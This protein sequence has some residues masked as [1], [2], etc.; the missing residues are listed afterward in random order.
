MLF[1]CTMLSTNDHTEVV[2]HHGGYVLQRHNGTSAIFPI[3]P[4]R[5]ISPIIIRNTIFDGGR[6][7]Y[8]A[9]EL[10]VGIGLDVL[11]T[12]TPLVATLEE[13]AKG[14]ATKIIIPSDLQGIAGLTTTIKEIAKS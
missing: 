3:R 7:W 6:F 1:I 11:Y 4:I 2:R 5:P 13:V 8:I 10:V 12:G 14:N 9:I